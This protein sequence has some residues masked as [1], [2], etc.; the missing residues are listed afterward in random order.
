MEIFLHLCTHASVK[1]TRK[2]TIQQNW[3]AVKVRLHFFFWYLTISHIN[4]FLERCKH[5]QKRDCSGRCLKVKLDNGEVRE[6]C[7]E[8]LEEKG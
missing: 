7:V 3:L 1:N 8:F 4:L 6:H 2:N 5:F